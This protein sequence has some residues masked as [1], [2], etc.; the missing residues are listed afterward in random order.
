MKLILMLVSMFFSFQVLA[1]NEVINETEFK[2]AEAK[3]RFLKLYKASEADDSIRVSHESGGK[4]ALDGVGI[5]CVVHAPLESYSQVSV[6]PAERFAC[7][8]TKMPE[9]SKKPKTVS[10]SKSK[11]HSGAN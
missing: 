6:V 8:K 4:T 10:P 7:K 9:K 1:V 2:G 3:D 5:A 11:G